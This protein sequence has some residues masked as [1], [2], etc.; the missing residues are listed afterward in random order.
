MSS[1]YPFLARFRQLVGNPLPSTSSPG[2]GRS[3]GKISLLMP[4]S[5]LYASPANSSSDLFWAFQPKRAMVP[6]L[7]LRLKVPL[8]PRPLPVCADWLFSRVESS[9]FSTRP[10]PNTGVGMRNMRL[11]AACAA[12]KLG[13]CR[14]QEPASARPETV[15]RS[16]TPPLGAAVLAVPLAL[17]KN[18]KRASRV[19]P[20]AVMK[21]GMELVLPL[22]MPALMTEASGLLAG[23][24]PPNVG[25][26]WQAAH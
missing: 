10:A 5:T 12:L 24:E 8:M 16:S 13:C 6:S 20:F 7:P 1:G 9:M 17:K 18:G 11:L 23:L 3:C 15:N 14:L 19:G 25:C 4:I 26:E 22:T 21:D 2:R